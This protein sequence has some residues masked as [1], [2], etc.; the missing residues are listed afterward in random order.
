MKETEL[1]CTARFKIHPGKV[2]EWKRLSA[3]C[4][5]SARSKDT[6]TIEYHVFLSDDESEGVVHER[7]RDSDALL[8]HF[9]NLGDLMAAIMK[10]ATYS[11]EICGIPSPALVKA[12]DGSGVR[13]FKLHQSL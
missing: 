7:Y 13:A 11:G 4:M 5:E 10:V 9:A 6:G 8:Q 3:L 1:Y 12:L 2:D